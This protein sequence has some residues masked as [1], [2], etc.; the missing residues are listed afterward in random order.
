MSSR[1]HG[2]GPSRLV[3]A[4]CA[5]ALSGCG[6]AAPSTEAPVESTTAAGAS[7]GWQGGGGAETS[8]TTSGS[9]SHTE[10]EGGAGGAS[11]TTSGAPSKRD[12]NQD[13]P[14]AYTELDDE[15][16]VAL[17]GDTV[18]IHCAYPTVGPSQGPY[19]VVVVAHGFQL[20]PSQY[21][22][23]VRRLATFGYVA[24][25]V[26]FPSLAESGIL[27]N[28][29]RSA[30]D[31]A[32][33]IDWVPGR[34]EVADL[35]NTD[36]VGVTGHSLGG[37]LGFLAATFDPRIKAAI[38]LDPVDSST[39][40]GP[41]KC[42]DVSSLMGTLSIPVGVLGE[43]TDAA[44]GLTPCA[45]AADNFATFF[46]GANSPAL[47]VEVLGANHLGFLD[48]AGSCGLACGACHPAT[49]GNL[50]VNRLA[51][52]FVVAFYE[53]WLRGDTRYD[54]DL[55]GGEAK[56]RYVDPGLAVIL[57]K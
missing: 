53:R 43:G 31:V 21:Y 7:T 26:D 1:A 23:Y 14:Y 57:S 15:T 37:K 33:A 54:D 13:G 27:P 42:P 36:L 16:K 38:E 5:L 48:D 44:G 51:R 10:G 18:A 47:S 6:D 52:A 8:S 4:L 12:P 19:P 46:A 50:V 41:S 29:L 22:G 3:A 32:G 28:H 40:C 17:T 39:L 56:S 35:A 30:Q 34:A 49:L 24:L 25:T 2:A 11:T 20:S 9:T 45:P 55:T